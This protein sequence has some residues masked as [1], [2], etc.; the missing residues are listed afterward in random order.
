MSN[1]PDTPR[2]SEGEGGIPL[3]GL[4]DVQREMA[5]V[6]REMKAKTLPIGDGNGLINALNCIASVMQDQRDSL[7]TKRAKKLW[8]E[9]EARLAEPAADH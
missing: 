1:T 2:E 3:R 6:Y 7:W 8:D 4:G 5:R 9:R